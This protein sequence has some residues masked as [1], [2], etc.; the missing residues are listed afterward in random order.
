[1]LVLNLGVFYLDTSDKKRRVF[2]VAKEFHLANDALIS[3]LKNAN[4]DVQNHM[5]LVTDEMYA[6]VEKKYGKDVVTG[7]KNVDFRQQLKEKRVRDEE[8]KMEAQREY[9]EKVRASYKIMTER[10]ARVRKTVSKEISAID[11]DKLA[12]EKPIKKS[13]T[14]AAEIS[15]HEII[16]GKKPPIVSKPKEEI[17]ISKEA[18]EAVKELVQTKKPTT[19]Q[20]ENKT[21]PEVHVPPAGIVQPVKKE[22]EVKLIVKKEK[23]VEKEPQKTIERKVIRHIEERDKKADRGTAQSKE[24][25]TEEERKKHKKIKAK[26]RI[27]PIRATLEEEEERPFRGVKK[28]KK[29]KRRETEVSEEPQHRL[30]QQKKSKKRK[31]IQISEAEVDESIKQTLVAMEEGGKTRRKHKKAKSWDEEST[32][33]SN[34]LK[35][36]DLISVGEFAAEMGVEPN[37]VIKKCMELGSIVTINHRLDEESIHTI[38]E[39]FGFGIEILQ[40]FGFE[41]LERIEDRDDESLAVLR[42]PVVTIMGHVDHGKTSLL[43]YIQESNITSQESGGITQ[44]I[45]AY[46]VKVNNKTITFLDTPGHE[47]FAA[48]RARGAQVTDIVILVVAADDSVM[49]QTI[50]AIAHAKAANVPIIVAINKIDKPGADS[51]RIKKQLADHDVLVESWGGKYQSVDVSAKTGEGV[52]KLLESILIESEVL[53]LK[54]NPDRLARGVIIESKLDKGKGV[55]ASV[56]IQKGTLEI[57]DPFISGQYSGK[58]RSLYDE[59]GI[60][61]KE[62]GPSTPI[63]VIG[64]SGLPQAGDNFIVL[65]S[66][67]DTKEISLSRQQ[68]KREQDLRRMKPLTLDEI[69][70]RIKEGQVKELSIILKGDVDGSVEAI[71]EALQKLSNSEVAVKI[72]YKGVGGIS[73][74]DVLL[75]STSNAI[76]IGF[77]VRPSTKAREIAVHENVDIRLYK[78]IYDAISHVKDALE[79]LLE[80]EL[81]EQ[82]LSVIEIR[83]VFRIPKFGNIAGCYVVSGKVSRNDKVKL[84]RDDRLIYDGKISSLKRLKDDAKEVMSGFECG[85]SLEGYDDIKINDIIETYKITETKRTLSTSN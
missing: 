61:V 23:P 48:M 41:K 80:P 53:E 2:Q 57:G 72:L 26:D 27:T 43:D 10:P 31:K 18:E 69:S 65:E 77:N 68:I 63:Q 24:F 81:N 75:A 32:E 34:I 54:A 60:R 22:I 84:F 39:E 83:E 37:E 73:E 64:F 25:E 59:H 14:P 71:G 3:F 70:R 16:K 5:A 79:G 21:K 38:A 13:K 55:V 78:I 67:K 29:K 56:L 11:E 49:P 40:E 6:E 19:P 47:A 17:K 42:P 36:H 66:E 51:A 58:V 7:D 50:E 85:I 35:V 45:G 46:S 52:D 20:K 9:E 4:F 8:K 15:N 74:S 44:H 76:I 30:K 82:N 12:E 1:V 33:D 28:R 62:C